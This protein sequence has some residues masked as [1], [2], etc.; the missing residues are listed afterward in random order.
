M[1]D[2]PLQPFHPP[3]SLTTLFPSGFSSGLVAPTL[4]SFVLIF[5]AVYTMVAVYHWF[6]YSHASLVAVPAIGV[7]L[8]VSLILIFF[9][10]TGTLAL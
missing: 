10:L 2:H 6:K 7:H 5:W 8:F 3:T 9:T 1:P 4:L